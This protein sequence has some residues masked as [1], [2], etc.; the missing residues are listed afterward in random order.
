M[1]AWLPPRTPRFQ[2]HE[3]PRG[4]ATVTPVPLP[5]VPQHT[6]W[7]HPPT[8]PGLTLAPSG[9]RLPGTEHFSF[10]P[11]FPLKRKRA[12]ASLARSFPLPAAQPK[13]ICAGTC[14]DG[15]N[16]LR[17][18]RRRGAGD[19]CPGGGGGGGWHPPGLPRHSLTRS[20]TIDGH[21]GAGGLTRGLPACPGRGAAPQS[22]LPAG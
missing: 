17:A 4:A 19:P 3:H 15:V 13:N 20:L 16:P 12:D 18:R 5:A 7:S 2:C 22:V 21:A 8:A 1:P 11:C 6:H 10:F 14:P 9:L